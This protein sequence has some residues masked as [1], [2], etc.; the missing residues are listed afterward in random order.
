MILYLVNWGC[1]RKY[2]GLRPQVIAP[3]SDD[4]NQESCW[5]K[6]QFKLYVCAANNPSCIFL[7]FLRFNG[8]RAKITGQTR[9]S[10]FLL[11]SFPLPRNPETACFRNAFQLKHCRDS[12]DWKCYAAHFVHHSFDN[13][14]PTVIC[15]CYFFGWTVLLHSNMHSPD[16]I[17]RL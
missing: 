15:W 3:E 13:N 10:V 17:H 9:L 12:R 14:H 16:I 7:L 11:S 5:I 1:R 8:Y 4:W 6:F 2:L